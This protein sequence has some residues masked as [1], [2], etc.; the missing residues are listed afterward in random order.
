MESGALADNGSRWGKTAILPR[1][2]R[3]ELTSNVRPFA[4]VETS[5]RRT[6]P[7]PAATRNPL[8]IPQNRE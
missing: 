8:R 4:R 2:D 5:D 1:D 6:S 7:L 3:R